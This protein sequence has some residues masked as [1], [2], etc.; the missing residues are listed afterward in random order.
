MPEAG[1]FDYQG[2][3]LQQHSAFFEWFEIFMIEEEEARGPIHRIIEIGT[4]AGGL[5][6]YLGNTWT[7]KAIHTFDL[8]APSV[9]IGLSNVTQHIGDCDGTTND[10]LCELLLPSDK[11]CLVLCDGGNKL[12][13]LSRYAPHLKVGVDVIA[14]HDCVDPEAGDFDWAW[15]E[16]TLEQ[17]PYRTTLGTRIERIAAGVLR[18]IAWVGYI[19]QADV[20]V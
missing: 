3:W 16:F 9:P 15:R 5:A 19:R 17:V 8:Q 12:A 4:G 10:A 6:K 13:E 20:M 11:R 18:Q 14:A 7:G 2:R 1:H